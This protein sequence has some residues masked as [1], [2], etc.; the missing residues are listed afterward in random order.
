MPVKEIFRIGQVLHVVAIIGILSVAFYYQYAFHEL[1]CPL[2]LM[3]R[4]GFIG[5]AFGY[6]LNLTNASRPSHYAI[7]YLS[8]LFV[9]IVSLLQ[10]LLHIAPGDPGYGDAFLGLHFYT[11]AYIAALYFIFSTSVFL[12]ADR[13]CHDE[14]LLTI[15]RISLV[16]SYV[17]LIFTII[18][19]VSAFLECGFMLCPSDPVRYLLLK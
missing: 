10:I 3:Q 4:L 17:L 1:P 16:V 11:W 5:I 2:C 6:V 19:G 18:N 14:P 12:M 9:L 8:A 15:P 7:A 13:Q